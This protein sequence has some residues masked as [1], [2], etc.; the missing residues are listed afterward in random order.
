MRTW[1][2]THFSASNELYDSSRDSL[3]PAATPTSFF[4]LAVKG[5]PLTKRGS[6]SSSSSLPPLNRL[7][8]ADSASDPLPLAWTRRSA[9]GRKVKTQSA[10]NSTLNHVFGCA[11]TSFT[12]PTLPTKCGALACALSVARTETKVP[13]FSARAGDAR[14][15]AS[16][17]DSHASSAARA[18]AA[19]DP[20]TVCSADGLR[21]STRPSH[22]FTST[23]SPPSSTE[24][25]SA[26]V[27]MISGQRPRT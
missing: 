14:R 26:I 22:T 21:R 12:V 3:A 1:R 23:H 20:L 25:T 13:R 19:F 10:A 2:P 9:D 7:R 27:P 11:G 8:P 15:S 5:L 18:A 24:R 6:D 17:S 16:S 4:S